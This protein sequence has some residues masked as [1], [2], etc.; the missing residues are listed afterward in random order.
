MYLVA[1]AGLASGF[2]VFS[3]CTN[4]DFISTSGAP[5]KGGYQDSPT[6]VDWRKPAKGQTRY[7]HPEQDEAEGYGAP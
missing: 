6:F 2:A 1:L 5:A 4:G 3:G 7:S